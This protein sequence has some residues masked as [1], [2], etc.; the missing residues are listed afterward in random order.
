[1]GLQARTGILGTVGQDRAG[2]LRRYLVLYDQS[3]LLRPQQFLSRDGGAVAEAH[4]YVRRSPELRLEVE[5]L[6]IAG[7]QFLVRRSHQPERRCQP[8]IPAN[9]LAHWRHRFGQIGQEPI[10]KSQLQQWYLYSFWRRLPECIFCLAVFM[11]RQA[12][13]EMCDSLFEGDL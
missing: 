7:R 9:R 6:G 2:C 10:Y 13:I 1:M 4:R 12:E 8:G 3:E 11:D 5:D